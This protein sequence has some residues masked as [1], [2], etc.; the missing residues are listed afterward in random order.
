M[1]IT[2]AMPRLADT[3]EEG[4]IVAW[5]KAPGD[6][7]ARG[8]EICEV[9]MEKATM[10]YESYVAGRLVRI[11]VEAGGTAAVGAPIAELDADG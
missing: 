9:E 1:T 5:L 11:L 10:A 8:E 6:L 2:L 4:T 3:M 7:V